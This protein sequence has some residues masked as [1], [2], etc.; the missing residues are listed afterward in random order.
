MRSGLL[1]S[2]LDERT[3]SRLGEL[4]VLARNSAYL[5]WAAD[6]DRMRGRHGSLTRDEMLVPLLVAR[7]DA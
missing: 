2:A 3:P 5:W 1:G 7:L 6:E 4:L